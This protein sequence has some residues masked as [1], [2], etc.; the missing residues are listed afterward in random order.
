MWRQF[1]SVAGVGQPV[2][3]TV[4]QYGIIE[5]AEP[6]LHAA[7]AGDDE[8]GRPESADDQ[9]VEVG[10]LRGGEAVETQ[11]VQ[12]QQVWGEEGAEG[13]VDGVVDSGLGHG[14][15]EVVSVAEADGVAG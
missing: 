14:P 12:D 8:A 2:Q 11:V 6:F 15:E 9:L 4:A 7:I 13:P 3:S 5:E 1:F 10:G